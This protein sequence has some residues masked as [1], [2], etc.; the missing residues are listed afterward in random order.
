MK[1]S[2]SLNAWFSSPSPIEGISE[3]E[4][5]MSPWVSCLLQRLSEE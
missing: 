1:A 2:M 5:S 4:D 3:K